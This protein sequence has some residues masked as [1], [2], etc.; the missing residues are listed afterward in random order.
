MVLS[1]INWVNDPWKTRYVHAGN[2]TEP[3]LQVYR[4]INPQS[5]KDLYVRTKIQNS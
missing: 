4:K 3:H 1:K 5:I 2:E